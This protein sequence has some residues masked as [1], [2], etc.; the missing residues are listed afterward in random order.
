M[1]LKKYNLII[2]PQCKPSYFLGVVMVICESSKLDC[3]FS[4]ICAASGDNLQVG[5]WE[6]QVDSVTTLRDAGIMLLIWPQ[7]MGF[8]QY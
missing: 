4:P 5:D 2:H 7:N 8:L 3:I 6:R 1:K